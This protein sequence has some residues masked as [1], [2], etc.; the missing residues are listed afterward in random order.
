MSCCQIFLTLSSPVLKYSDANAKID[1][2][3]C[4]LWK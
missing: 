2:L 1:I 4:D 3:R